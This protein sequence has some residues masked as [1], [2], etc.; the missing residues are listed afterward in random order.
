MPPNPKPPAADVPAEDFYYKD[1]A[2]ST[3]EA[4]SARPFGREINVTKAAIQRYIQEW[5][6]P[7][8]PHHR[9]LLKYAPRAG[10]FV[11]NKVGP[12]NIHFDLS[13]SWLHVDESNSRKVQIARFT[14]GVRERYPAVLIVDGGFRNRTA[15]LGDIQDGRVYGGSTVAVDVTIDLVV[16]LD[17]VIVALDESTCNDLSTIIT[18]IMGPPLRRFGGGNH[19]VSHDPNNN[20]QVTLPMENE[21]GSLSRTQIG[22]DPKD[23]KWVATTSIQCT[24]EATEALW[25][26]EPI[27]RGHTELSDEG[28]ALGEAVV[29]TVPNFDDLV[30]I[31]GPTSI[32]LG[33]PT[34]YRLKLNTPGN[35][36]ILIQSDW[37][38]VVSDWRLATIHP[39]TLMLHPRALGALQLRLLDSSRKI[40]K[41]LD[42]VIGP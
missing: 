20:W 25:T 17:I 5:L 4:A 19:I 30:L 10:Q 41:T 36:E 12:S 11:V 42:I 27:R 40:L 7:K 16:N 26:A 31:D 29:D 15:G 13:R 39:S 34:Q 6:D 2:R 14:E 35:P 33:R 37:K 1:R 22:D 3:S 23:S 38:L 21:M 28:G 18:S 8:T 32:R 24:F 9:L